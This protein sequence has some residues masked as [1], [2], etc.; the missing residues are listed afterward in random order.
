MSAI[1]EVTFFSLSLRTFS[2]HALAWASSTASSVE[3]IS[4]TTISRK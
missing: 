2:C 4:Y 1:S 3:D